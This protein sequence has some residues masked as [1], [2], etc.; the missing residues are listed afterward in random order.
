MQKIKMEFGQMP[1]KHLCSEERRRDG[2][3]KGDNE[4]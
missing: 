2:A 3:G 4:K 1:E